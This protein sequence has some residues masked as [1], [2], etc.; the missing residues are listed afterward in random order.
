MA[1]CTLLKG[2]TLMLVFIGI[3]DR[4]HLQ[5]I[6]DHSAPLV[7]GA[8]EAAALRVVGE[9]NI[10]WDARR[11]VASFIFG[12]RPAQWIYGTTIDL[13]AIIVP[14]FPFLNPLP[15]KTRLFAA[16]EGDLVIDWTP[17]KKISAAKRPEIDIPDDVAKLYEPIYFFA[18]LTRALTSKNTD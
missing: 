9:P 14:E 10:K 1:C 11:G 13:L 4:V 3:G 12:E 6:V 2:W 7:V 5:K 15:V 17:E 8:T 16:N 18:D